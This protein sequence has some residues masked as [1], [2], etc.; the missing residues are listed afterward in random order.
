MLQNKVWKVLIGIFL[1]LMLLAQIEN[2]VYRYDGPWNGVDAANSIV[3]GADGNIYAAGYSDGGSTY[4]D[5]TVI[6]LTPAGDTNWVYRYNGPGNDYDVANSIIYGADGN[7]YAAGYS[8]DTGSSLDFTVI[9]IT[10]AGSTNWVYRY[11]G[12]N[13]YYDEANSIVYGADENIYAAGYSYGNG[14][15]ED[16]T[17]I[18]LTPA[19]S[20]NW[21]YRYNGSGNDY[22]EA[23]SLVCGADG[24][25]Y[26]AGGSWNS[27]TSDDFTV[28]S[29]TPA[30]STNWVYR[31][32]GP[33][34]GADAAN[35]IVYGA[36]GNIYAAGYS[37]GGSTYYDFT[38]VSLFPDLGVKEKNTIIKKNNFGATILS[39]PLLLPKGKNCKVFD[40]T[41]RV[42]I[43]QHMKPG[44]YFIEVDGK[45]TQKVVKVR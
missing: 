32:N 5:F 27:S 14:T 29:L 7:I 18:S 8:I 12:P 45:I 30:G 40:I 39:G 36:D 19:G 44:I 2:W 26:A 21:V 43:P 31:Y 33:W 20:T 3:Y 38:V 10:P 28:I 1:P 22:D 17:V 25:I 23:K 35:S 16:F 41:G 11:N 15:F 4:Y 37:D 6:C 34:N 24:N 42:V 9:S 13:S